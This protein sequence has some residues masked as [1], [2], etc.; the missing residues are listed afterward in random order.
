MLISMVYKHIYEVCDSLSGFISF[1]YSK[2][3]SINISL[4]LTSFLFGSRI[5]RPKLLIISSYF[6][7]YVYLAI[8]PFKKLIYYS[9]CHKF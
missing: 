6:I 9:I 5:K 7:L 8:K 4:K 3:R 1:Y 2:T